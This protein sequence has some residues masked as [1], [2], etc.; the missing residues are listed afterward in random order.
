MAV[1]R[2]MELRNSRPNG[3]RAQVVAN[4]RQF[5]SRRFDKRRS[6]WLAYSGHVRLAFK[7][8]CNNSNINHADLDSKRAVA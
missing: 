5:G 3:R 1:Y 6:Q 2:G 7:H 4:V 8:F